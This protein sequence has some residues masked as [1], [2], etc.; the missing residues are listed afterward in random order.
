MLKDLKGWIKHPL[1]R[2][3]LFF[4]QVLLALL[5]LPNR[6]LQRRWQ[7]AA[8]GMVPGAKPSPCTRPSSDVGTWSQLEFLHFPPQIINW[9]MCTLI[10]FQEDLCY[11]CCAS[12]GKALNKYFTSFLMTMN[13][14]N[15]STGI[16][17]QLMFT[18]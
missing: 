10:T 12:A 15:H 7:R 9:L 17:L 8:A 18:F 6:L 13:G 16:V 11:L 4:K 3:W 5:H 14:I 2:G 1:P